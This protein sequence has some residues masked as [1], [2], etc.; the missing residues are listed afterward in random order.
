[1]AGVPF[2]GRPV[3]GSTTGKPLYALFELLGRRW[4]LRIM[5]ELQNG[6]ASFSELQGRCVGISTST[7]TLRLRD[8]LATG[9]VEQSGSTYELTA[10]GGQLFDHMQPLADWSEIWAEHLRERPDLDPD[11]A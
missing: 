6:P 2:P 11:N 3:R 5:W 8:L 7:L 10:I 1:M 4:T 9:V